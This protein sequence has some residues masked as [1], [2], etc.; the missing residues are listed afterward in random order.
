[1]NIMIE[2]FYLCCIFIKNYNKLKM[3]FRMKLTIKIFI[4][5]M[6]HYNDDSFIH[7]NDYS[8]KY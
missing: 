8:F 2:I 5:L 1:M 4:H 6:N 3:I 7:G